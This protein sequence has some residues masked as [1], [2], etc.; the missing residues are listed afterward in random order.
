[1]NNFKR[2]ILLAVI[3]ASPILGFKPLF[4]GPLPTAEYRIRRSSLPLHEAVNESHVTILK[5]LL[6]DC[7]TDINAIDT[8]G[9]TPLQRATKYTYR[10][11]TIIRI[12]LE[13]GAEITPCD[14]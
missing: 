7:S 14:S 5:E 13:A 3:T 9:M 2:I 8:L 10:Y 6:A 1:M 12:L 4:D 11:C